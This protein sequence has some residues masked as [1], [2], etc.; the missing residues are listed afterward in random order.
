MKTK[1]NI[2]GNGFIEIIEY[3]Y[4]Y[5]SDNIVRATLLSYSDIASIIVNVGEQSYN[6]TLVIEAKSDK[7][8]VIYNYNYNNYKQLMSSI[9]NATLKVEQSASD[10]G[11]KPSV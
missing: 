1:L 5:G 4:A 3:Y 11:V 2:C 9:L 10:A 6:S 7:V 8:F